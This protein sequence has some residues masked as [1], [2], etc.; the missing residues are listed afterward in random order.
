MVALIRRIRA[1]V[2]WAIVGAALG[3]SVVVGVR[4]WTAFRPPLAEDGFR[5]DAAVSGIDFSRAARTLILAIRQDCPACSASMPFYRRLTQRATTDVQ[6][7]VAVPPQDVE[8]EGYLSAHGVD[9]DAVVR[10]SRETLPVSATPTLL[11]VNAA[12]FV[13]HFWIGLLSPAAEEDLLTG[14]VGEAP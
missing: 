11:L 14:L 8:I 9:P 5:L 13:E 3:G 7:V 2:L 6:V 4:Q 10:R 12:G 1:G